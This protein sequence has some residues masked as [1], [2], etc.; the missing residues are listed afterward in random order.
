MNLTID[1]GTTNTKISIWNDPSSVAPS[2]QVK[3]KTPKSI[4]DGLIDFDADQL[5]AQIKKIISNFPLEVLA[6]VKQIAIASVGESGVLIDQHGQT[7]SPMIAWYDCR[8]QEIIDHLTPNEKNEI[9]EITGLPAHVHYSV[10]KIKWLLANESGLDDKQN[11][12]WLCIPDYLAYQLTGVMNSEYSIA[13]R[14]MVYD[15][16]NHCWS[17]RIKEIFQITNI[18]FPALITAGDKIGFVKKEIAKELNLNDQVKVTI[19]GHDHMVGSIASGQKQDELLDSTGTTEGILVL[20]DQFKTSKNDEEHGIAYGIYPDPQYYTAFTA[21]PAV[22]S[23]IQWFDELYKLSEEEFMD[24]SNEI[25]QDYRND[26]LTP[27]SF[28]FVIPHFNGSG[29]PTKS[30]ITKGLWYG[31]T[32]QTT[33][34]ELIF[35]LFLGLTF[36][37]KYALECLPTK[38]VKRIKL[39]GPATKDPI[40]IQLRADLL[41]LPIQVMQTPESVSRGANL[42]GSKVEPLVSNELILPQEHLLL[43]EKLRSIY[44]HQYKKLYRAKVEMEL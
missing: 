12:T 10:S 8:S 38:Q 17:E 19:A 24:L 20:L 40:W 6:Q 18:S 7:V 15:L 28:N 14:T 23:V 44:E 34:K 1:V 16:K 9:Y 37:L 32:D 39:I 13:S 41:N 3:F 35:G 21:L 33:I 36:E 42:I 22:G 31:L 4:H 29:S 5:V 30:V 27:G 26:R 2:N 25:D 43:V 11:Y